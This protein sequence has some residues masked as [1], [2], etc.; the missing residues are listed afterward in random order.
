MMRR[1]AFLTVLVR[2]RPMAVGY[3]SR[4]L[5]IFKLRIDSNSER[6]FLHIKKFPS[7]EGFLTEFLGFLLGA[8]LL[9]LGEGG[10]G[11]LG[12]NLTTPVAADLFST[13][14]VVGLD[15]FNQFSEGVAVFSVNVSDSYARAVLEKYF[16][17]SLYFTVL[18][19]SNRLIIKFDFMFMLEKI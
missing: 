16:Q 11:S 10:L 1:G 9:D 15:R 2:T 7:T 8:G 4:N 13:L 17:T 12:H 3:L 14:V 19:S 5:K 18:S 6:S